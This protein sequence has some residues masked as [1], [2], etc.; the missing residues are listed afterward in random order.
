VCLCVIKDG[1]SVY[2][3]TQLVKV[4]KDVHYHLGDIDEVRIEFKPVL[5]LLIK[6]SV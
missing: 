1:R 5:P 4:T 6:R 3:T 2:V